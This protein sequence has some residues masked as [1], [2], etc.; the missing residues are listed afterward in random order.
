MSST[1]SSVA[2]PG[3]GWSQ[4]VYQLGKD[5]TLAIP[6]SIHESSRNKLI[7]ILKSKDITSGIILLRGGEESFI[8]DT[9]GENLFKQDSWFNYLFGVKEPGFYGA[10]SILT[11]KTTLFIPRLSDEYAI[12]AG[13]IYPPQYFQKIYGVNEV[14]YTDK[15][16]EWLNE[17][18]IIESNIL[19]LEG[20]NSDSGSHCVPFVFN[21]IEHYYRE[22]KCDVKSL[23]HA[24]SSARVLKSD[25]EIEVMRYCAYI[26]SNAHV[27]VMRLAKPGLYEYELEAKFR[28]EIYSKGGCRRC[29]YTSICACGPNS[30]VLH[31]GHAGAPNDRKLLDND[32]ALLDMGAEYHGYVSDITC[33]YPISGHFTSDQSA[34]YN[35][36]LAAQRI[37]FESAKP[38]FSWPTCH[39][40]A[41]LEIIKA[42]VSIGILYN[43]SPIQLQEFGLGAVFFPHGL[44]HLI[45]CDTHDVGGYIEGTPSR[46]S[47]PGLNKLRTARVLEENMVLTNEPGCYFIDALLDNAIK[48]PNKSQYINTNVLERFRGFGGVRIEDVFV[49]TATGV[50]NLTTC[51]R[52][53]EEVESVKAGGPWPPAYDNAPYLK[54]H[55]TRLNEGGRGMIDV[56]VEIK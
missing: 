22:G 7:T 19:L 20:R 15:F 13:E 49:V 41:E 8:Y 2:I 38:G 3:Y 21:G 23:F 30:A 1:S 40:L 26:A 4:P 47:N 56:N 39:K 24:L 10:I 46:H 43:A 25:Y 31:Y 53:I 16:N 52:L 51:P 11:G 55:W 35:G 32:M 29:A 28:Y 45:G 50:D 18:I 44:G 34:I 54:R 9:D 37:V 36:V 6:M 42:L 14:S 27:E 12:W 17:E 33:S 48:D 5:K